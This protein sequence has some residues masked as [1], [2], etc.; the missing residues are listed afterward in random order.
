M[1]VD[2]EDFEIPADLDFIRSK[3]EFSIKNLVKIKSREYAWKT[4][5]RKKLGH[6]KMDNLWYSD[7]K[8]QPYLSSNKFSVEQVRT[9]L[10][11]R[12]RMAQFGENFPNGRGHLQCP[13]C[14]N[15]FD[16][17]AMAFQCP[18]VKAKMV[19]EGIYQ[20]IFKDEIPIILVKTLTNIM[21]FRDEYLEGNGIQ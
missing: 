8:M 9:L 12:T 5:M 14:Q 21:K 16:S 19:L 11:F 18:K 15:H 6:T 2:L 10:K 4:F 7:R 17:Q 1:K 20:D 13:L 3:S